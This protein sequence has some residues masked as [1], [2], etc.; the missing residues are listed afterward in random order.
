MSA[1]E[2]R[3]AIFGAGF[4][5]RYQLSAW[6]ELE[7]VTCVAIYNRTRPKAEALARE[8]GI[9]AVYDTPEDLLREAK[10]DFVDNIT[11]IAGHKPL[12]LLCA[13]RRVP[14]I[15]Q[16]P[17]APSL[18]AA[19]A[20]VKAFA[21]TR[22]RFFVHENWRWQ[23]PMRQLKR[24][25]DS[26]VIGTPFRGRLTMISGYDCWA[27]QPALREL[28]QFILTDLGVHILDVA[29][30]CFGEA[31]SVYCQIRKTLAPKVKGENVATL[32]LSMGPAKTTVVIELGY[33]KTPLEPT[34]R[35]AF[36]QTLAFVEGPLGSLEVSADYLI[37]VTTRNGTLIERHP[38]PRYPWADSQYA[39]AH[40]SIVDCHRDLLRA[41]RGE[42]GGETTGADNLKTMELTYA[43]YSS[44]AEDR[45]ISFR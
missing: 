40:A 16:K 34:V 21:K 31:N 39:V 8:F 23:T 41:L 17:M 18:A 10:P 5:T 36:P 22:T 37:K 25:I 7:G 6:R 43:A 4:W 30:L 15:C 11:E 13:Q 44:A 45:V 27:N 24:L 1:R 33:A 20:M 42:G 26:G 35:E 12:S 19:R 32:L 29:R 9:P 2:L 28:K 3:F 38:P 14:C